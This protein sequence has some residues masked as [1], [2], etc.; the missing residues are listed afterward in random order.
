MFIRLQSREINVE[1]GHEGKKANRESLARDWV[2][3]SANVSLGRN[4]RMR[5]KDPTDVAGPDP[6]LAVVGMQG[7]G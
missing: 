6:T 7:G 1:R 2:R 3:V 5:K 4:S